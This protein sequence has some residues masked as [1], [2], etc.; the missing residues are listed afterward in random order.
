[1][2]LKTPS[3]WYPSAQTPHDWRVNALKPLS[4]FYKLAYN[5][6]QNSISAKKVDIPVVC[7]G[8]LVAGGTGKTPTSIAVLG[9]LKQSGHAK[10]PFF[11]IRG[12]GGAE[13]GPLLVD[14]DK[15]SAWDVGD[16]SLIL[17]NHAPTIVSAD[18]VAGAKLAIERGADLVLMDDGLQNPGIHKDFKIVVING[19]MGF[20]NRMVMPAGPLREPLRVGLA[21]A[22]MFILIGEDKHG[23]CARLPDGVPLMRASLHTTEDAVPDKSKRYVAFAGLGYPEKFFNYLKDMLGL[24]VVSRIAYADHCPYGAHDIAQL[25]KQ[26]KAHDAILI[27]T[28]KDYLR[29]PKDNDLKVVTVPVNMVFENGEALAPAFQKKLS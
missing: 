20:G 27:T 19:E 22:D 12:Y 28:E 29:L 5:I 18:R 26:A 16:E 25:A 21:K 13:R 2:S 14:L 1:M 11:L 6:H 9:C 8:N 4:C 17:A 7:V 3:F 15:H 23:A 10:N 24:N